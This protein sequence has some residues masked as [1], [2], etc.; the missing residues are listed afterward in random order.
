MGTIFVKRKICVFTGSRAEYGLLYWLMK[1]IKKDKRLLL[2]LIVTGMHLDKRFGQTY[3]T[4]G[5]DGFKIDA[6]VPLLKFEDSDAGI[7]KAIGLGCAKFADVLKRIK[8]D[9]VVILGDRYEMLPGA[10][11]AYI[12]KIPIAHIHGGEITQGLIDEGIRHSITKL[13]SLHF[14]STEEYRRRV[15]QLGENPKTVFYYGAPGLDH[16]YKTK[17]LD[18]MALSKSL[19]FNL[20]EPFL[21][22][23]YHPVTLEKESPKKQIL[24]I[25][26]AVSD[27]GLNAVFTKANADPQG[28]LINNIIGKFCKKDSERYRLFDSLGQQRYYSCLKCCS[29]MVGNSS[30]GIIEAASFQLPVVNIGDRQKNR[31]VGANVIHVNS[32]LAA[33]KK[34][35]KVALS[36][37]FR[38]KIKSNK[39]NPYDRYG[40]GKTSFRIKQK[41][42]SIKMGEGLIK[43]SFYDV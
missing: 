17:L 4:I 6:K 39:K 16:M 42:A 12:A 32:S 41:L 27:S 31:V 43:K 8:P 18:C 30:S 21:M 14:V 19:G 23:T 5:R 7:T 28:S 25:L 24:N 26:K 34:G 40:D 36:D 11:A 13:S 33:I 15:V 3:K 9:M 20:K 37:S 29:A 10:I 1:E 35:I 22:V 38:K 2:Q